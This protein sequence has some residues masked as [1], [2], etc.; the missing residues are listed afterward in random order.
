MKPI[1]TLL[2]LALSGAPALALPAQIQ[3]SPRLEAAGKEGGA[4]AATFWASPS[5]STKNLLIGADRRTGLQAWDLTGTAVAGFDD[6]GLTDVDQRPFPAAGEG[7]TLLASAEKM[8]G[9]L[10]FYLVDP[11]GQIAHATPYVFPALPDDLQMQLSGLRDLAL[12]RDASGQLSAWVG[13]DSGDLVQ[14]RVGLDDKGKISLQ[15]LRQIQ[16]PAPALALVADDR[17]GALFATLTGGGTWRYPLSPEAGNAGTEVDA[18]GSACTPESSGEEAADGLA[19]YDGSARYL[20]AARGQGQVALYALEDGTPR[21]TALVQVAGPL[22][23]IR[24]LGATALPF[25]PDMAQGALALATDNGDGDGSTSDFK[26][27]SWADIAAQ[28]PED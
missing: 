22:G 9:V 20:A 4:G 17:D 15:F 21:C 28:L 10:L 16:L 13:F 5:D 14:W 27:I 24:G 23:R 3:V 8:A 1:P 25:G 26:V 19:L 2:A 18:P 11:Q 12:S 7:T 6:G